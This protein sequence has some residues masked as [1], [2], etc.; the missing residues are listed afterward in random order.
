MANIRETPAAW[1]PRARRAISPLVSSRAL[2]LGGLALAVLA[3]GVYLFVQV[4]ASPAEAKPTVPQARAQVAQAPA[5][6][7]DVAPVTDPTGPGT[8][9]HM[10][11]P[12]GRPRGAGEV[13]PQVELPAS[14]EPP[15]LANDV[16]DKADPRFQMIMAEA[17]KAYDRQ[18]FD[19]A[20]AIATKI[21]AKDPT[22]VRMLR[23]MVSSHCIEGDSVSAQTYYDKLPDFD[24]QQMSKRCATYG[25]SFQQ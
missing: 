22:N 5:R 8:G 6:E 4:H 19:E 15:A 17:N 25:V 13:R 12:L 7:Q 16:P 2:V 11:K 20:R 1:K 10:G 3:A 23:I 9:P 24:R 21:L 14:D 18:D